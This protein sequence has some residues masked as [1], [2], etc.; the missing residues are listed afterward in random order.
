MGEL[1]IPNFGGFLSSPQFQ[2]TIN[3]TSTVFSKGFTAQL[4]GG[5]GRAGPKVWCSF[6]VIAVQISQ[7][8][9]LQLHWKVI[10]K[11]TNPT[12]P[13]TSWE[14]ALEP[15]KKTYHP[16]TVHFSFGVRLDVYIGK[17]TLPT[18]NSHL[19]IEHWNCDLGFDPSTQP[20]RNPRGA[21]DPI[22]TGGITPINDRKK[23]RAWILALCLMEILRWE[24]SA[25]LPNPKPPQQGDGGFFSC[26]PAFSPSSGFSL[27]A[28]WHFDFC[29]TMAL[30]THYW[31]TFLLVQFQKI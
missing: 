5:L 18:P 13:N 16:N 24:H 27:F 31:S 28:H 6:F 4:L 30:G 22:I 23:L 14:D 9:L 8:H 21:P 7:H 11:K 1:D 12:H 2:I 17:L 19:G 20:G 3:M 26:F 25:A 15:P 10:Q 29:P